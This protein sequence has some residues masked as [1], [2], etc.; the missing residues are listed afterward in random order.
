MKG[1]EKMKI[2]H[3]G[4]EYEGIPA[5]NA[6]GMAL[7]EA[8]GMRRLIDQRCNYDPEKRNL[9][10]GMV[11]KALIGPTFNVHKKFPLYKVETAYNTA[12]TDRLFGPGVNKDDLYDTAL[13]RGLDTLYDSDLTGLFSECSG[14]ATDW[15]GFYSNVY[16]MDSTDVSYYGLEHEPDK[17]G[18]AVPDH[19][20]HAKDLHNELLQY[21]LQIVTNGNRIIRYMRPYSGGTSD[22]TMDSDT[23]DDFKRIFSEEELEEMIM[24]GDC[25][26]ATK[27]N[28]AKMIDMRM[29]F[30]SKCSETFTGKAKQKIQEWSVGTK[31]YKSEEKGLWMSD[32]M[33]GVELVKGRVV[34]LRFV[35]F[36][37][38]VKVEREMEKVRNKAMDD[39]AGII[40]S[41]KGRRFPTEADALKSLDVLEL[42]PSGPFSFNVCTVHYR[43]EHPEDVPDWWEL[44]LDPLISETNIR[45]LAEKR[46]TV[47]LVTNMDRPVDEGEPVPIP[48]RPVTNEQVL[49]YYN[50]EY[51]VEQSFRLMKSGM[52]MN[53]I[54][55]QTPSRENAMMFV[56]SIAVLI[57]NIADA[58]FRRAKTLLDGRQLTMYH[59]AFEVQNTIVTYSR[60]ENSLR[61]QGP[62]KVTSRYFEITDTLQIN[63]QYLLG[64]MSD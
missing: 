6:V 15:C 32:T 30:V 44:N 34:P 1:Q 25:K 33:M 59:L 16:H 24:V 39:A 21:E 7:F 37:W 54:F 42:N 41:Y 9:S 53:S 3:K 45:L 26:L 13:A 62:A 55:L 58:M 14:L 20:G 57:S 52:G 23:L 61:L 18:A 35:A 27:A 36:R 50:Q 29:R 51:K 22:S 48:Y 56:I 43:T 2:Q 60:D 11:V 47:V 10:P 40:D 64:Y 38:D 19:N 5:A 46:Q 63:P 12:P 31:M 4:I 17:D 8:S 49:A 28:I